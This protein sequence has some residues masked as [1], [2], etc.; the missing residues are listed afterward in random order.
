MSA[1]EKIHAHR[2]NSNSEGC[3]NKKQPEQKH[4]L[5][6]PDNRSKEESNNNRERSNNRVHYIRMSEIP[7]PRQNDL[8]ISTALSPLGVEHDLKT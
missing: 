3:N 8:L 2:R 4:K 6:R 1:M 7:F 5:K